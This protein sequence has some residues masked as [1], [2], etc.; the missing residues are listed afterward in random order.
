MS[1]YI[2]VL[3][4]IHIYVYI[5]RSTVCT[6]H[7]NVCYVAWMLTTVFTSIYYYYYYYYCTLATHICTSVSLVVLRFTAERS[8]VT[9]DPT[10]GQPQEEGSVIAGER[11]SRDLRGFSFRPLQINKS[12]A[13]AF[14]RQLGSFPSGGITEPAPADCDMDIKLVE[15]PDKATKTHR[16]PSSSLPFVS[17]FSFSTIEK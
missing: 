14:W 9:A 2:N 8:G 5:K 4:H 7:K 3:I 12:A 13:G 17:F 6:K 11:Q 10:A 15:T 1:L 16:A